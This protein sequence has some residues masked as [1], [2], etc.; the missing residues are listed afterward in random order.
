[1]RGALWCRRP[2]L[3]LLASLLLPTVGDGEEFP[4]LRELVLS[5]GRMD[6]R[7]ATGLELQ[8]LFEANG[9]LH[10]C[11]EELPPA[12]VEGSELPAPGEAVQ[13]EA[14]PVT[15]LLWDHGQV[16]SVEAPDGAVGECLETLITGLSFPAGE[17]ERSLAL[18]F[19]GAWRRPDLSV[20]ELDDRQKA[21]LDSPEPAVE[22]QVDLI[23]VAAEIASRSARLKRCYRAGRRRGGVGRSVTLRIRLR[24]RPPG[25]REP[26]GVLVNVSVLES[27]LGDETAEV[28]IVRVFDDMEYPNPW[29]E[30]AE[31]V[32]PMVFEEE[33][34]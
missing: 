17:G 22:G 28:C 12:P 33:S 27:E 29:T 2:L 1:M 4:W 23:R 13:G 31:I 15:V 30:T 25:S 10:T 14:L 9:G 5:S 8:P 26:G 34:K 11:A 32:W 18:S 19:Q 3:V 6:D 20:L 21:L 16:R 24:R 7:A